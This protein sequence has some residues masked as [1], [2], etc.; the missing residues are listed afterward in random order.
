[1]KNRVRLIILGAILFS[2]IAGP[3]LR[4]VEAVTEASAQKFRPYGPHV[5]RLQVSIYANQGVERNDFT[6]G[7][8]DLTDFPVLPVDPLCGSASND[9]RC[10]I[11]VGSPPRR[12]LVHNGW[13]GAITRTS[14]GVKEFWSGIGY[15]SFFSLLNMRQKTGFVPSGIPVL[16]L[17]GGGDPN[18]LR[19]GFSSGVLRL[20]V[21]HAT[22]E[23]EF[24][25]LRMIYDTLLISNPNDPT[26][27]NQVFGWM[28][29]SHTRVLSSG[30]TILTFELRSDLKWHDGG[31]V[32][33]TDVCASLSA[34]HNVPAASTD[35][36]N[37]VSQ[38][39]NC[40]ALGSS[41]AEVTLQSS[42]PNLVFDIGGLPVIPLHLWDTDG[43]QAIT[44]LDFTTQSDFDPMAAGILVGSGPFVC[45]SIFSSDLDRVGTGCGRNVDGSRSGQS[46]APGGK[47]SLARYDEYMRCCPPPLSN[48][49]LHKFSWADKDDSG[50][51]ELAEVDLPIGI[52]AHLGHTVG[53]DADDAYWDSGT[54][55][56]APNVGTTAGEVDI[57]E[58]I[59][60]AFYI[61]HSLTGPIPIVAVTLLDLPLIDPWC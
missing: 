38:L 40:N 46:I 5:A 53:T 59:F 21:F 17:P 2:I 30:Q 34:Y 4:P 55:T 51:V 49:S 29:K 15:N 37:R 58:V 33:A 22:T 35:L 27:S 54:N 1:M 45:R 24:R 50:V 57:G 41:T 14:N 36:Q 18:L 11:L 39:I 56:C 52:F 9:A 42:N 47:V 60:A 31:P 23:H 44:S 26:N 19:W 8:L 25:V 48:T 12:Y 3:A 10:S 6:L 28:T 61:D 20:N 7:R 16:G 43:D 32:T 13:D